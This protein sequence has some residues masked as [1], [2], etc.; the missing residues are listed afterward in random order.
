[1]WAQLSLSVCVYVCVCE[2]WCHGYI[3]ARIYCIEMHWICYWCIYLI[4][5]LFGSG[6]TWTGEKFD[7]WALVIEKCLSGCNSSVRAIM[8]TVISMMVG[9]MFVR[10]ARWCHLIAPALLVRSWAWSTVL[11]G[12]FSGSLVSSHTQAKKKKIW[13]GPRLPAA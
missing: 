9:F 6:E 1:M 3:S 5:S 7:R 13:F 10:S 2:R 12:F 11:L 4:C 8:K